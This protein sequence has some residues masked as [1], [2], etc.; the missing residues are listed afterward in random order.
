MHI[1]IYIYS[2][3]LFIFCL[4][5]LFCFVLCLKCFSLNSPWTIWIENPC[6]KAHDVLGS[7]LNQ[8]H[9]KYWEILTFMS[10]FQFNLNYFICHTGNIVC[11]KKH[12]IKLET[13]KGYISDTSKNLTS[14]FFL[15][16]LDLPKELHQKSSCCNPS[17]QI[18]L[19]RYSKRNKIVL[20]QRDSHQLNVSMMKDG[21]CCTCTLSA[22]LLSD[23]YTIFYTF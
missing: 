12:W 17:S 16:T 5:L 21:S 23:F 11:H 14:V 20:D 10:L 4:L 7:L 9:G 19:H 15:K 13:N 22:I 18:S 6:I 2:C 8:G 3:Y 1:Y